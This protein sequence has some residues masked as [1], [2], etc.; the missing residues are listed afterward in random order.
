MINFFAPINKILGYGVHAINLIIAY[1]KYN[2][3]IALYP[4]NGALNYSDTIIDELLQNQIKSKKD[5]MGICIWHE[6]DMLR[7]CGK[8]RIG[9]VVF[10]KEELIELAK[11]QLMTL[12]YIIVVSEWAKKVLLRELKEYKPDNIFIIPEG[13]D[14]NIFFPEYK[15]D[16]KLETLKEELKFITIGKFEDR[17]NSLLIL[18]LFANVASNSLRKTKLIAHMYNHFNLTWLKE[19]EKKLNL[20]GM[21]KVGNVWLKGN[22]TIQI[23]DKPFRTQEEIAKVINKSHFG[24]YLSDAEGWNLPLIETLA[25]GI[26][27][28]CK[29]ITGQTEYLKEYSKEL[30]VNTQSEIL[31][32]FLKL[33][34]EPEKY[35]DENYR[36]DKYLL[37]NFTWDKAG[38]KLD[39]LIKDIKSY[40][41]V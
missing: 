23:L 20:W 27:C 7:F 5:D 35:L 21:Q 33:L 10:E 36:Y 38:K 17:K 40:E 3:D 2:K 41:T 13:F 14:E 29:N 30:L 16:Y 34:N 22:T 28:V 1:Y 6:F 18:E 24:I 26:P 12:N 37:E 31:Q 19:I 11:T 15:Q 25:C 32:T 9:L 8:P 4:I 39:K